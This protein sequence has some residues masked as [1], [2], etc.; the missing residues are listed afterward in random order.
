MRKNQKKSLADEFRAFTQKA[1]VGTGFL[2]P[3]EEW[4]SNDPTP[5]DDV[6][7]LAERVRIPY[8]FVAQKIGIE[9]DVCVEASEDG[10]YAKY[11]VTYGRLVLEKRAF[12]LK[13]FYW[14]DCK[15][16]QW[17]NHTKEAWLKILP[18]AKLLL[19]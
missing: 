16:E 8:L 1:Q 12:S 18:A 17:V 14:N 9:V 15:F 6:D 7:E 19:G 13:D 2:D 11:V 3:A 4:L 5:P 10:P